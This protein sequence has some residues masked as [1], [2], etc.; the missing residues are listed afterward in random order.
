GIRQRHAPAPP[1]LGRS[2]PSTVARQVTREGVTTVLSVSVSDGVVAA[3]V[4]PRTGRFGSK[5]SSNDSGCCTTGNSHS[6][7]FGATSFSE[8]APD[9]LETAIFSPIALG[10]PKFARLNVNPQSPAPT[11]ELDGSA[12][13]LAFTYLVPFQRRTSP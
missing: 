5:E 6:P 10:Q 3:N 12:S 1:A 11:T 9:P 13:F 7:S 2:T 4:V 8:D